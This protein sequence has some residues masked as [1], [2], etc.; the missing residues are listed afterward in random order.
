[1]TATETTTRYIDALQTASEAALEGLRAA[2]EERARF[3]GRLYSEMETA[4]RRTLDVARR[5]VEHPAD[6][7]GN[8]VALID[9][10][11]QAQAQALDLTRAWWENVTTGSAQ[12]RARVEKV[13]NAN[14]EAMDAG[15]AAS[16]E[17]FA[18]NPVTEMLCNNPVLEFF[19]T[20]AK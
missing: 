10:Q 12:R 17:A 5:F 16:R 3:A 8:W 15:V 14:R 4:Q 9:A 20:A 1:M 2:G 11:A 7:A 13:W 18:A 6:L 19:R